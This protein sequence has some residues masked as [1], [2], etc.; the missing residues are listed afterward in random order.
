METRQDKERFDVVGFIMEFEAG[1]LEDDAVIEGFQHLID[2]GTV[3]ALQGLYG[4]TARALI[5]AGHCT[6]PASTHDDGPGYGAD[7]PKPEKVGTH[8]ECGADYVYLERHGSW[9]YA[10]AR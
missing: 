6:P 1:E 2:D 4:R 9:G 5:D 8:C 3:W 10:C 7:N